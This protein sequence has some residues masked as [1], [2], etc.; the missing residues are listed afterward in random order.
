[1]G[2]E[3]RLGC[4]FSWQAGCS[5]VCWQWPCSH[6]GGHNSLGQPFAKAAARAA[7][8]LQLSPRSQGRLPPSTHQA[9]PGH[10]SQLLLTPGASPP[11]VVAPNPPTY[12]NSPFLTPPLIIPLKQMPLLLARTPTD[13]TTALCQYLWS[14]TPRQNF[15]FLLPSSSNCLNKCPRRFELRRAS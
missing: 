5:A 8:Q 10:S 9:M 6:G 13:N 15:Y 12:K 7:R 3:W 2:S 14:L 4:L 11:V 1:M